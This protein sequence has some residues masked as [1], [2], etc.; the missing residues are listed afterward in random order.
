MSGLSSADVPFRLP[1]DRSLTRNELAWI[2]FLRQV[3]NDTDPA[4][5]LSHVQLLRR[6]PPFCFSPFIHSGLS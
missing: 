3:S 1:S 2:G 5:T 4:P 6:L